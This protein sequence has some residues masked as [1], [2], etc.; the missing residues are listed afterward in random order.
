[1]KGEWTAARNLGPTV[2]TASDEY[3]P[4]LSRN[5]RELY[6]VRRIPEPGDFYVVSTADLRALKR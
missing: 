1:M 2:N 5:G 6:F 3:H 4:T